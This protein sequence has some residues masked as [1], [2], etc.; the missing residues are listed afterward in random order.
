MRREHGTPA[1]YVSPQ[2]VLVL[3]SRRDRQLESL[4][5]LPNG[6]RAL[7]VGSIEELQPHAPETSVILHWFGGR[8]LL[9]AAFALC[10]RLRWVHSRSAGVEKI[11]FPELV[12]SSVVLTNG[13]GTSSSALAEFALAAI[14]Y[15]AKDFRR[16]V[17]SQ[18]KVQWDPFEVSLAAGS[19]VGIVGFGNI[20]RAVAERVRSLGMKVL[21]LRRSA[22]GAVKDRGV[23]VLPPQRLKELIARSDYVVLSAPLTKETYGMIGAGELSA[24]KPNAVL[25]NLGRG[26]LVS[27]SALIE[28]LETRRIR[29]AALDVFDCEPLSQNHPFYRLENVLLSPHCA[30]RTA[31][32]LDRAMSLFL[33]QFRR[34]ILGQPLV[35]VVD[36]TLGY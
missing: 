22:V 20:G 33:S 15:F 30:D 3:A 4:K 31:D 13:K 6:S 29:G 16:M 9:E 19:I 26:P 28:A 25:I 2:T 17:R 36:K 32:C 5:D 34:F 24:A 14:L 27:E 18:M 12:E 8:P 7:I 10:P 23:E 35:N 21:A 1:R 11:L